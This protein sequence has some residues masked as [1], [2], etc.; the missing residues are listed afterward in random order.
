MLNFPKIPMISNPTSVFGKLLTEKFNDYFLEHESE[1]YIKDKFLNYTLYNPKRGALKKNVIELSNK[2]E[3]NHEES[4]EKFYAFYSKPEIREANF[5]NRC[6]FK[7]IIQ[8]LKT[9]C[10]RKINF[11]KKL[12][13]N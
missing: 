2:L 7:V 13:E 10:I 11:L 6:E 3:S 1:F 9:F 5:Y 8:F 12:M 4:I